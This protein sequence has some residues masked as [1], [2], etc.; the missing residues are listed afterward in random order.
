MVLMDCDM[1][2]VCASRQTRRSPQAQ[3]ISAAAASATTASQPATHPPLRVNDVD[4]LHV[5]ADSH[6]LALLPQ[7]VGDIVSL[8]ALGGRIARAAGIVLC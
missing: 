5:Q 7:L 3:H 1:I 8:G 4:A 2:T 6:Q